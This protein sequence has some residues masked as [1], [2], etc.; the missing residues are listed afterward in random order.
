M[1]VGWGEQGWEQGWLRSQGMT[2]E[3]QLA[4]LCSRESLAPLRYLWLPPLRAPPPLSYGDLSL[5]LSPHLFTSLPVRPSTGLN[6]NPLS[7]L[8]I[9]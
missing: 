6:P 3:R 4:A 7:A 8:V 9:L 2:I 1:E 5:Y